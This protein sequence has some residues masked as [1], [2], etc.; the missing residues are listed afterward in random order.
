MDWLISL[1]HWFGSAVC[2]QL[3][4]HSYHFGG[5]VL[6]L[7][8]RCT[9]LYLGA[10]LTIG[11]HAWRHPRASGLPRVWMLVALVLFFFAWAGDGVNSF[12]AAFPNLPHLYPPSNLLRLITGTLMG[13][14]TGS[15]IYVMFNALVWRPINPAPILATNREFFALLGLGALLV[16][17]V[18]TE[19]APLL[20]PLTGSSLAAILI[21]HLALTSALAANLTGTVSTWREARKALLIGLLVALF[22][23]DVFALARW[24][25]GI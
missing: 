17:V 16:A 18:Q 2:D 25:V 21:L 15:F 8:A 10:L 22:Y 3:P 11:F 19:W 1:A 7:C 24:A 20:I 12:L 5:V 23:L 6:P 13:L 9:G 4:T 14:T